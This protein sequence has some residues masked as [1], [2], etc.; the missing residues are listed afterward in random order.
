MKNLK[1]LNLYENV[2]DKQKEVDDLNFDITNLS[3]TYGMF[4]SMDN[5]TSITT[6][7]ED[8]ETFCDAIEHSLFTPPAAAI[9]IN[10]GS[11]HC[12]GE[13][14]ELV[15]PDPFPDPFIVQ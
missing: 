11:R 14:Y 3:S 4:S 10:N 12:T 13:E 15:S 6:K 7:Q 8:E 5:L 1:V 2:K 9:S